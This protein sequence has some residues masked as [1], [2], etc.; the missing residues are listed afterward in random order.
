VV[1]EDPDRFDRVAIGN[2]GLLV[3][4]SL[5][6]GFDARLNASQ[7]MEFTDCGALLPRAPLARELDEAVLDTLVSR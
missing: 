3:L 6:P 1:A 4:D 5:G 2:T 7:T